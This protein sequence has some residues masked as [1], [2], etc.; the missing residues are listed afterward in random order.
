VVLAVPVLMVGTDSTAV[1]RDLAAGKMRCSMCRLVLAGWGFA[2]W[3]VVRDGGVEQRHRPHPALR[4]FDHPW[5]VINI[6]TGGRLLTSRSSP[7][8]SI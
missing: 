5:A 8:P 6:L 2:R 3:W 1:G 7:L 4:A